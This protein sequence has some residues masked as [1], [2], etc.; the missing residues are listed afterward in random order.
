[1]CVVGFLLMVLGN[2]NPLSS[3]P[4]PVA[5]RVM[6]LRERGTQKRFGVLEML[7]TLT[8]VFRHLSE[9]VKWAL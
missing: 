4:L 8:G 5:G 9:C 3:R 7:H 6:G 2:M 1:M